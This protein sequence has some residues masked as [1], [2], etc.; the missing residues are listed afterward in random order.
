MSLTKPS[1]PSVD[2]TTMIEV[3]WNKPDGGDAIDNYTLEWRNESDARYFETIPHTSGT[4][5][6]TY[7]VGNL[8]PGSFYR[9]IVISRAT[10]ALWP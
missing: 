8:T 3:G 5:S 10:C 9:F 7:M 4:T 6:Y 1:G 2:N